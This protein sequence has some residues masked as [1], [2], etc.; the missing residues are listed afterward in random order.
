MWLTQAPLGRQAHHGLACGT[1][2]R[3]GSR[4]GVCDV[5]G[6]ALA[7]FNTEAVSLKGKD[8]AQETTWSRGYRALENGF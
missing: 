5:K 6:G 4:K 3:R 2:W 7:V 8:H 1:W